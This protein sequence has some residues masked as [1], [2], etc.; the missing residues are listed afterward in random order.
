MLT[1]DKAE[2][3][4]GDDYHRWP[5]GHEQWK[6]YSH[7]DVR[8]NNLHQ[9]MEHAIALSTGNTIY[10]VHYD[11]HTGRFTEPQPV[12]PNHF[13][14]FQGL[15]ALA[16]QQLREM[17]DL[18]IFLDPEE[19]LRRLW[20]VQRDGKERGY[21]PEQVL[22][23]LRRRDADRNK[24]ILSQRAHAD[25]IVVWHPQTPLTEDEFDADPPLAL[26][27]QTLNSFNL[28]A[29]VDGVTARGVEVVSYDPYVDGR[30]QTLQLSGTISGA[31]LSA[32][33]QEIVPNMD[34]LSGMAPAFVDGLEGCLQL[35]T[36]LCL[37]CKL[38]FNS[39]NGQGA[40]APHGIGLLPIK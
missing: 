30:W 19:S 32:L 27:V 21:T 9:Q 37:S 35:I 29:F 16:I 1:P 23:S 14:I 33:A 8:G 12:R 3:I 10:K 18:R 36:L 31:E 40:P 17:Y 28:G 15:H 13:L 26:E 6:V 4:A 20:K 22:E 39:L 11:H 38:R 24:Y 5:R 2:V 34:E 7:L 25:L